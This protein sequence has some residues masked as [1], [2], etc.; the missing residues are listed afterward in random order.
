MQSQGDASRLT[1]RFSVPVTPAPTP[2]LVIYGGCGGGGGVVY[3]FYLDD[4]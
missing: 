2:N 3:M 1:L 4:I